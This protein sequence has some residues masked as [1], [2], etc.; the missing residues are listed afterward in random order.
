MELKNIEFNNN[1][2]AAFPKTL[3][4]KMTLE[5]AL[6]IAKVSSKQRG[7]SPHNSIF[8]CL[9]GDVFNR[10]WDDGV[11]EALQEFPIETPPIRYEEQK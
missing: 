11:D 4:V 7:I 2:G 5:E 6:W 9:V 10:Y 8:E 3:T 1:D